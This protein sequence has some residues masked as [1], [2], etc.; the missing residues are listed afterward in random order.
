MPPDDEPLSAELP[1][2]PLFLPPV[3]DK[4]LSLPVIWKSPPPHAVLARSERHASTTPR[5]KSRRHIQ[6]A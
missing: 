1:P 2:A 6:Q 5:F 4:P 3:P